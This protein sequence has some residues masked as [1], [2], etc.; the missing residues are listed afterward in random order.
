MTVAMR[1]C[2]IAPIVLTTP[3]QSITCVTERAMAEDWLDELLTQRQ[4][5]RLLKVGVS[6]LRASSCPKVLLPGNGPKAKPVVR[7]R[8]RDL[9]DWAEACTQRSHYVRRA[10]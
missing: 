1:Q 10:G 6:Y 8:V 7:Y 5:A 2:S 3:H 4:A 9:L